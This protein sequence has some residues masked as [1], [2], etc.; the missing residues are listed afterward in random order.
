MPPD[1]LNGGGSEVNGRCLEALLERLRD[2]VA[3]VDRSGGILLTNRAEELSALPPSVRMAELGETFEIFRPDGQPYRTTEWPVLRAARTGEVIVEEVFF[4]LL[5]DGSRRSFSCDCAPFYDDRGAIAGAV[6]VAREITEQKRM[7]GQLGYLLALHDNTKDAI[8]AAN[9]Q[10]RITA[11]SRGAERMFGWTA[12]EAPGQS[13]EIMWPDLSDEQRMELRRQLSDEGR[14]RGEVT[15]ERKDGSKIWVES[16]D[17]AIRDPQGEITGYLGIHRDIA[18]RRRAQEQLAYL[19][20]MLNHTEDAIIAFDPDWHVT[21]WNNG[22]E[23]MYGWSTE[24]VLGRELRSLMRADMKNEQRAEYRRE[25]AERGRWRGEMAVARKDGLIVW[26]ESI[27]VAIRDEHGEITGY[28]AIHRDVTERKQAEKQ[29]RDARRRTEAIL[30]SITDS[31]TALDTQWR[32]T[33]L[34]Q[35]A[36]ERIQQVEGRA[37]EFDDLIGKTVWEA[38]PHLVGTSTEHELR[39]ALREQQQVTFE[40]HLPRTGEWLEVHAYP[41][42][43]GGLSLHGHDITER[44]RAEGRLRFQASLLENMHDAALA[45][46]PEFVL[47]AWNRGA[48]RMFG[49]SV[50][51]A[52]GRRVA[53]LIP[54]SLSDEE[55]AEA[56]RE[57]RKTGRW[58]RVLTWYGKGD[59]PVE[60]EG[61]CVAIRSDDCHLSGYVCIIRDVSELRRAT[62]KLE[63]RARQ[64]ALL[65]ELTLRNLA[66]GDLHALLDDAVVL[67]ARALDLELATICEKLPGEEGIAWRAAHGWRADA[68]A[69]APTSAT[70][71]GSL[72]GYALLA[73]E[74]VVSDDVRTDRRFGTSQLFAENHPVS[75]VAVVIPGD[76]RPFGV[77]FAA[78]CERRSFTPEDVDFMKA[79]ANVVGV[80]VERSRVAERME[81]VR[82]NLRARIARDLHDDALREL[83]DALALAATAR[84]TVVAEE[85]SARWDG[86]IGALGRVGQH[87]RGAVYDLRLTDD[88]H[89]DFAALL[90]DLVDVQSGKTIGCRVELSGR[91]AIPAGSLGHRGI[92]VLRIV[93]EAITNARV[94]SG[95]TTIRVDTGASTQEL[96]GIEVSD[97]GEW[98]AREAPA[99]ARRGSGIVGMFERADELGAK[100]GIE[101]RPDGGTSVTLMLPLGEENAE[102]R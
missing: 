87:L 13:W 97:D 68:L 65:A 32:Y 20:P 67:V 70:G 72:P 54:T 10:G 78:A 37:I 47:T 34:N 30:E 21:A 45:T 95:G 53:E 57:L 55:H 17:V 28:L 3:F 62:R 93:R 66:A 73:G 22:A 23:R 99:S 38:F 46:D 48:E 29:L 69:H 41:A 39:R 27:N 64:Q 86:L 102:S 76:R 5:P 59:K 19:V 35:R 83:A 89:R 80:A 31:F 74:P 79:V 52:L 101:G 42:K 24:E 25:I 9:A 71:A 49:W 2:A 96:L 33:Y 51:E 98:P 58:R 85:E 50:A 61:L 7:Q 77:L 6:L 14:W 88:E 56:L 4:R 36:L 40:T 44:K 16:T 84:S 92:E 75:A 63:M 100:L 26:I 11:W 94:H 15:I 90:S 8:V 43:D 82:A 1:K 12:A 81:E 60:A 91:G 18:E